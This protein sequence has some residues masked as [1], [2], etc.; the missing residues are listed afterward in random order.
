MRFSEQNTGYTSIFHLSV[1]TEVFYTS[2]SSF[3]VFQE[4]ISCYMHRILE[5]FPIKH[6]YFMHLSPCLRFYDQKVVCISCFLDI[7][8]SE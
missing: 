5:S 6:V 4:T 1:P 2:S 8:P 3:A 7:H